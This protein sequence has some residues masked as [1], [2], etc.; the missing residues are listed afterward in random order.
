MWGTRRLVE[1]VETKS[2]F[3]PRSTS[4]GYLIAQKSRPGHPRKVKV[5]RMPAYFT[6]EEA[7][8]MTVTAIAW[9]S[10]VPCVPVT[11]IE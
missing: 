11:T 1:G 7:V 4:A 3:L 8:T 2:V 10:V 9:V 5:W 6:Y